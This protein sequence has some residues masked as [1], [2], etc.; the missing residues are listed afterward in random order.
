MM[1]CAAAGTRAC[2]STQWIP[3]VAAFGMP[4]SILLM[5]PIMCHEPSMCAWHV[6][7]LCS[8]WG[9]VPRPPDSIV[10]TLDG[11]KT[12]PN[13]TTPY[14]AAFRVQVGWVTAVWQYSSHCSPAQGG[15]GWAHEAHAQWVAA[16]WIWGLWGCWCHRQLVAGELCTCHKGGAQSRSFDA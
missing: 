16:P 1:V 6:R 8:D 5:W 11:L 10:S 3:L 14:G 4:T 12:N 2:C 13:P 15:C 9:V 7:V